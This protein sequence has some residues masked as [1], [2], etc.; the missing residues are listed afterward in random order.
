MRECAPG[1]PNFLE[2][3]D[4]RFAQFH[5]TLDALFRQLHSEGIGIQTKRTETIT[6]ED[7][8]KLWS[9]GV[10]GESTPKALQ[11]ATFFVVGK[12]FSLRGGAEHRNLKISHV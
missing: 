1:C 7:E 8:E 10:M 3:K 5:G 9:S 4:S 6:K 12:M 11:N 2:R